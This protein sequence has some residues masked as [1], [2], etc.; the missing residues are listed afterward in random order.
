MRDTVSV[1]NTYFEKDKELIEKVSS[2]FTKM[3]GIMGGKTYEERLRCLK[4]WILWE[5]R[6]R[7]YVIEVFKC[8]EVMS[9]TKSNWF[10]G[11]VSSYYHIHEVN[12]AWWVVIWDV[13]IC[14]I[15]RLLPHFWGWQLKCP[16]SYQCGLMCMVDW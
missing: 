3:I 16:I 5:R 1:W 6:D 12:T 2:R 8:F 7:Q 14:N 10:V 15:V 4:L 13:G 9:R 11:E